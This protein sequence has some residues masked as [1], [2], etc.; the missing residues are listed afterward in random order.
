MKV[1]KL[2]VD[3][4]VVIPHT[5]LMPAKSHCSLPAVADI[6]MDQSKQLQRTSVQQLSSRTTQ[7]NQKTGA[8][9]CRNVYSK[10][11][12]A[13]HSVTPLFGVT[14]VMNVAGFKGQQL[15][16]SGK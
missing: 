12:Q 4:C 14:K 7:S 3:V 15:P 8:E 11:Q 9:L 5:S 16:K 10:T 1:S 6:S 13:A 2:F